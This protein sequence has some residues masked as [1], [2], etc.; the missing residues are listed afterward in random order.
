MS[1]EPIDLRG[2]TLDEL[3]RLAADLDIELLELHQDDAGQVRNLTRDEQ[4]RF[5][6]LTRQADAIAARIRQCEAAARAAE[7]PRALVRPYGNLTGRS[8]VARDCAEVMRLGGDELRSAALRTLEARG[9]HLPAA[10][11]DRIEQTVTARLSAASPFLDGEYV[12][13][14]LLITESDEYRSAFQQLMTEDHPYLTEGEIRA[15]R[16][17]RELESRALSE[18]TPSA[19]GVGVPVTLDP[20]ILLE[21]GAEAAPMLGAA[22]VLPVTSNVWEG[23][24][25]A[26]PTFSFATEGARVTDNSPSL[27]QPKITVHMARGWLPYSFEVEMDYPSFA[28][29][30]QALLAQGWV[31]L[32]ADKTIN[33]TGSGEPFG[34]VTKLDATAGSEV[35]VTTAGTLDAAQIFSVWND[36]PE[37]FR[38]R[39]SWLMSVSAES[40][41]RSFGATPN[42]S[43]YF[44]CDLTADGVSRLNG[45][46][47]LVTDYMPT[48]TA[49]NSSHANHLVV[50]DLHAGVTIAMRQGLQ[51]ERVPHLFQQQT[52][53]TGLAMPTAQRGFLAW[54]RWGQDC[55]VPGALRILNQ[56]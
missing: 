56:T 52:A 43:A 25:S 55:V 13:R 17:Y 21:S 42:P 20:T 28:S 36:L 37:R 6:A 48:F 51:V 3:N 11:Q 24:S 19:G 54:G 33:G 7:N 34:V 31:D 15:L 49:G 26:P 32:M 35:L 12:S 10:A 14:R 8:A 2:R 5:D 4:G 53:G 30:M 45:R 23:V 41:I 9:S 46:S 50:G 39:S 18:N 29:E 1:D 44:T 16:A 22:R 47:V 38:A 27:S 40:A